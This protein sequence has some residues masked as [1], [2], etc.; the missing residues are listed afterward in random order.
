[1]V[2]VRLR[3]GGGGGGMRRRA[4]VPRLALRGGGGVGGRWDGC[5]SE[6]GGGESVSATG[7]VV[8]GSGSG[9]GSL[10]TSASGGGGGRG[11]RGEN[12]DA[13]VAEHW[14]RPRRPPLGELTSLAHPRVSSSS[15]VFAGVALSISNGIGRKAAWFTKQIHL[16]TAVREAV[17]ALNSAVTRCVQ[18]PHL[19]AHNVT[20][21]LG[22]AYARNR[23]TSTN[24]VG[25]GGGESGRK[26]LP[27]HD[28]RSDSLDPTGM[29]HRSG[30]VRLHRPLCSQGW[31]CPFAAGSAEELCGSRNRSIWIRQCA[32]RCSPSTVP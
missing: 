25:A 11:A 30:Y 5:G 16:D 9:S 21:A 14:Q 2:A 6:G 12:E 23:T 31:P 27:C 29:S 17:L 32:K 22:A 18:P 10:A 15:A 19:A 3:R 28:P 1:L 4:A 7:S 26:R 20:R 8:V 13:C 24:G